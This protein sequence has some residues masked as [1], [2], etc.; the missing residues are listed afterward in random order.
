VLSQES[1]TD[2]KKIQDE[3][4]D[5]QSA[6][7]PALYRAQQDYG[8]WLPP[9]AFDEVAAAMDLSPTLVAAAASFYTMFSRQ[10]VGKH[11]IQVCTNI[12]CSL[13]GAQHVMDYLGNKLGI[14]PGETTAD[15]AFT[16]VEVE[17]LGSCGT[18]PMM[19]VD[20]QYYENLTEDR[21][22]QILADLSTATSE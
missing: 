17:C 16:L 13:V 19:Q 6:L 21:I 14:K 1:I 22:D 11:L 9:E 10:P 5:S 20:D 12:S 2:I 8:G 15:G 3:Y 18:A 4:P 7:L